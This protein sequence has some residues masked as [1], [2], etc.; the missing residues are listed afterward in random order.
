MNFEVYDADDELAGDI[1][2][3]LGMADDQKI[4][5]L[6][7]HGLLPQN[8]DE[9]YTIEESEDDGEFCLIVVDDSDTEVLFLYAELPSLD[10]DSDDDD[11]D[12]DEFDDDRE[13]DGSE[14]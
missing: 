11:S 12:A 14:D 8:D 7:Q 9:S 2:M 6:K 4:E 13:D 3:P 10:D 5:M 1:E